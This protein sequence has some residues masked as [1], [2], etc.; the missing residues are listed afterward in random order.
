M[1]LTFSIILEDDDLR[2][3]FLFEKV[4]DGVKSFTFGKVKYMPDYNINKNR[5]WGMSP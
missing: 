2:Q 4:E 1:T 5:R 3:S